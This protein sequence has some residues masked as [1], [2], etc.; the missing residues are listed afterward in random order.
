MTY[1]GAD[2]QGRTTKFLAD[3]ELDN[4]G[5]MVIAIKHERATN[6]FS[7]VFVK[8]E[9]R[10]VRASVTHVIY[11]QLVSYLPNIGDTYGKS[12]A[13]KLQQYV[14]YKPDSQRDREGSKVDR[15][16]R[17][18]NLKQWNV[19][20]SMKIIRLTAGSTERDRHEA[21]PSEAHQFL[22]IRQPTYVN[23]MI[24]VR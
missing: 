21:K 16:A 5:H 20:I 2:I 6:N 9:E 7:H 22:S 3:T 12:V 4:S 24:P 18:F 1:V 23:F 19:K 10:T 11:D 13:Q 8:L 15:D 17:M 14:G